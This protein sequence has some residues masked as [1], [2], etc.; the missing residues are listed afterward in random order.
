MLKPRLSLSLPPVSQPRPRQRKLSRNPSRS[1][2]KT[3]GSG[4]TPLK[5]R[6]MVQG[7]VKSRIIMES[8]LMACSLTIPSRLA[9][10]PI[11]MKTRSESILRN[12]SMQNFVLP[13]RVV[14]Q[15]RNSAFE[16]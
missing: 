12:M 13:W 6:M 15:G 10:Y 16:F 14:R 5:F 7:R 1:S 9:R 8:V 3:C 11:R 2:V 4:N